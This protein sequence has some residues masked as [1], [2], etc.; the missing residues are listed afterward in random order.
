MAR[1]LYWL[2]LTLT[3]LILLVGGYYFSV[4]QRTD[5]PPET[6][7]EHYQ[8]NEVSCWFAIPAPEQVRCGELQ[9]PDSSGSFR[10]PVVRFLDQSLA[11]QADPVIYIQGGPGG[12]AG[13]NAEG[14]AYWRN[15]LSIAN[16]GRDF[17]IIDPRGVGRSRPSLRCPEYDQFSL[18]I[19]RYNFSTRE[20]L[21]QGFKVLSDCFRQLQAQGFKPEH[22]GTAISA[23]DLRALMTLLTQ[24]NPKEQ[25]W[26]LLGVSYGTRVALTAATGQTN[27][28]SLILDSVYPVG[29]GGLQAWPALFDHS[30]QQF[31]DWCQQHT[32]ASSN[33]FTHAKA[34]HSNSEP[35]VAHLLLALET[36]RTKPMHLVIPRWN[37]EAP[38][39]LLLNDQ[40][41]LAAVFSA[42]Y[43]HHEWGLIGPAITAVLAGESK[44]LQML[45]ENF[46]NYTF[47]DSFSS[48]VFMAVDCRDHALGNQADYQKMIAEHPMFSAYMKDLW[49]YQACHL[50]LTEESQALVVTEAPRQPSLLLAGELDPITPRAWAQA[51]DKL[52]PN[53]RLVTIKDIGHGVINSHACIHQHLRE[54]LDGSSSALN[55]CQ[56]DF[57]E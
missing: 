33:N 30:I 31:F 47:D 56:F 36:L 45:I 24:T 46:I 27:V 14:I 8:Y 48:L 20:E 18:K 28:R 29:Y 13:L 1:Y 22:Y 15:W 21:A 42:M 51:Q 34:A 26:N 40:R 17:I 54:F 5:K 7:S 25:M 4:N 55:A 32:C 9:T 10:L 39:N 44:D 38:I 3:I 50:L 19:L 23:Q 37:G 52:W 49:Q 41:F 53:A 57:L 6:D 43:S 2:V 35:D 11:H 12:S 16:L